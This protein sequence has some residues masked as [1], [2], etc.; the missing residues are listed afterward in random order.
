MSKRRK[1]IYFTSD[2]HFGHH[3]V[4]KFDN[5]PFQG[6]YQM[7]KGIIKRW[8]SVVR[9]QD[10][11]YH[12]GDVGFYKGDTAVD[13]MH[14]IVSQL[15]GTKIV[16]RGNHDKGYQTLLQYGFDSAMHNFTMEIANEM[17]TVS[18]YPL[19]G[20]WREDVTGMNN[21]VEGDNWHGETK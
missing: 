6:V 8:N 3:N 16:L 5:R 1:N 10:I 20:V 15:N 2:T 19:I 14:D 13:K 7:D 18:H 11:V 21:A 12:L 4:I 17:V 9:E